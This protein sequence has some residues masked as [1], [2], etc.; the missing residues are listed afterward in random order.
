VAFTVED[1]HD[2]IELLAQHPEWRADLRRHVLSEDLIELPTLVRQLVEAQTRAEARLERVETRLD[3]LDVALA[4][5][6]EA[7]ARTDARLNDLATSQRQVIDRLGDLEGEAL[8]ARY[9]RLGASY[10][11]PIARRLR[12]IEPG[13]L[14]DMLD[15]AVDEGLLTH[16]ERESIRLADVVMGGRRREDGLAIYLLAE[17]SSGI[18]VHDVERA[19]ERANLLAKLGQPVLPVVAGRWI[20]DQAA[21]LAQ[22]QGV[23]CALG[24]RIVPPQS[25]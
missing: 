16:E 19:V 25:T 11:G 18:G 7:Q 2:L 4:A 1:F 24:G 21:E 8:E 3:R 17:V 23:W 15:D 12:V 6:A 20:N 10:F 9:A 14:F 5:L 22:R 13:P